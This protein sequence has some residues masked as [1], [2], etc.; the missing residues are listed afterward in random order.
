[1]ET[2]LPDA[3]ALLLAELRALKA[4]FALLQERVADLEGRLHEAWMGG[5]ACPRYWTE[6]FSLYPTKVEP[7]EIAIAEKLCA[8]LRAN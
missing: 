1:M 8:T 3:Y 7:R 6:G 4:D 2:Q 5:T